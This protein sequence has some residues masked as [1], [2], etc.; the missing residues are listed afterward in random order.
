M[1]KRTARYLDCS[2]VFPNLGLSVTGMFGN[3]TLNFTS[4]I[5]L[6]INFSMNT[7]SG[8]LD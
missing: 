2:P 4:D 6:I 7:Q 1:H 5:L 8:K 3:I